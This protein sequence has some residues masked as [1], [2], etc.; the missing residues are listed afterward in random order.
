MK[1]LKTKTEGTIYETHTNPARNAS[2]SDAGGSCSD[3]VARRGSN[4]IAQPSRR[5]DHSYNDK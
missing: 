2:L 1:E 5:Y 3:C 4:W